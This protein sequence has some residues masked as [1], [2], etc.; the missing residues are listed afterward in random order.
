MDISKEFFVKFQLS[1][2]IKAVDENIIQ[3]NFTVFAN[4]NE[5]VEV[6]YSENLKIVD[7]TGLNFSKTA[8]AV[9]NAV[10]QEGNDGK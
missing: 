9:I 6:V 10:S 4:G 8:I 1:K 5:V 7:V 3:L 2:F